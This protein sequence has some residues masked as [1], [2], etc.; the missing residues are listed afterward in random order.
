MGT[1][2]LRNVINNTNPDQSGADSFGGLMAMGINVATGI[3]ISASVITMILSGYKYLMSRGDPKATATAH[4]SALY[5]VV[6]LVL[7]LMAVTLF[8]AVRNTIGIGVD[9]A[10]NF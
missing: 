4:K 1:D 5:S 2:I 10:P 8:Y 3:V 9:N 7:A 6:A